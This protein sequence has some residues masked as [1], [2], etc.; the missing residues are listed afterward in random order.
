MGDAA[1]EI[2]TFPTGEPFLRI[3]RGPA[4]IV[5]LPG[6]MMRAGM[7]GA[8]EL[9]SYEGAFQP[10]LDAATF[11]TVWRR[12]HEGPT[13]IA[14]MAANY[15]S[16][17][18]AEIAPGGGA[19][20]V[21]GLSTGGAIAQDLAVD[22]PDVV[23]RLVLSLTAD[24]YSEQALAFGRRAEDLVRR[25][26]WRSLYAML[27]RAMYPKRATRTALVFWA[28]GPRWLGAPADTTHVLAEME[29]EDVHDLGPR[30]GEIRA[31]TLVQGAALDPLYPPERNR[32]LAA[33]IPAGR[34]V[35]YPGVGH[36]GPGPRLLADAVAFLT[37]G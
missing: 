10:H 13:S 37:S 31:P 33:A 26:K 17:I 20:G 3:G 12:P 15:A 19:V 35:E 18:R 22:H 30:L 24:R 21:I 9:G 1:D 16:V 2:G 14:E 27:A 5:Y 23:D 4:T 32:A 6:L 11:W 29:A 34:H 8:A 25:G 28:Y 36:A 7:P